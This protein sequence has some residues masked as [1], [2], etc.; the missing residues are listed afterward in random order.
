MFNNPAGIFDP[1]AVRLGTEVDGS[2]SPGPEM[3]FNEARA[4]QTAR[5]RNMLFVERLVD[6]GPDSIAFLRVVVTSQLR[7]L[8][9]RAVSEAI[10]LTGRFSAGMIIA[11]TDM[12]EA[13]RRE[14]M[15]RLDGDEQQHPAVGRIGRMTERVLVRLDAIQAGINGGGARRSDWSA[16]GRDFS[17][18]PAII[19]GFP[20]PDDNDAP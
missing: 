10:S 13:M 9:N 1:E 5:R 7:K 15:S 18:G 19:T 17:F 11:V 4:A 3:A 8:A 6:E 16:P 14:A 2:L 20:P 12:D